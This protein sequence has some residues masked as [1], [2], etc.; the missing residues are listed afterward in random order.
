MNDYVELLRRNTENRKRREEEE[1]KEREEAEARL[2]Q[3]AKDLPHTLGDLILAMRNL[4]SET[5]STEDVKQKV[6][7]LVG[8]VFGEQASIKN[9][10]PQK[11]RRNFWNP[12]SE[13]LVK[14]KITT[15]KEGL[16]KNE[17]EKLFGLEEGEVFHPTDWAEKSN[18]LEQSGKGVN[19][20]YW[21]KPKPYDQ[22]K[23]G[24]QGS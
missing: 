1:Q 7:E 11:R 20:I 15:K 14:E 3:F 21:Y 12:L 24:G 6:V 5:R 8:L 16:R 17:L 13:K 9:P 23:Y 4:D 22:K 10:T 18:H 19:T 2:E